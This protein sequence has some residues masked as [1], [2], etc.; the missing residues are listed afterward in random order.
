MPASFS[1]T[2]NS[3]G[4]QGWDGSGWSYRDA[5]TINAGKV[6]GGTSLTNFPVLFS[7]TDP[8]LATT[9]Q[10]GG[11]G[12]TNGSDILFTASDG[13]TKLNH[14]VKY[15]NGATGQLIA[16]VQVPALSASVNTGL[17]VYYGNAGVGAQWNPSGVWDSG[18]QGV[19]HLANGTSLSVGDSS[20]QGN[21]GSNSGA[22]ATAGTIDGGAGFNGSSNYI[23]IPSASYA[24]YPK[25]GNTTSYLETTEVWFK[26]GAGGVILGQDDGTAVG[27]MP[28]GW[29]PG[30]YVDST[31]K[32]RASMYWHGQ[33]GLQI[34]SAASYNNNQW[35]AAV[36][37]Y[38]EGTETLY[39]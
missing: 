3:R 33:T 38:N 16:W 23:T 14:E 20:S 31:G 8:N 19:W 2:N 36:D 11:V 22:V 34:V 25:A 35:H 28:G 27:R 37:V 21:N 9:G 30:L 39:V 32:I 24:G 5:V 29:V 6:A 12:N 4:T 26:T 15:Y 10:G 13:V 1:L 17:Y 18:Y 7:V